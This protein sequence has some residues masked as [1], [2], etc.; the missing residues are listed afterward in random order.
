MRPSSSRYRAADVSVRNGH[1]R[2]NPA[3]M[4]L[5]VPACPLVVILV[6]D[7]LC[8]FEFG[9][10]MEVFALSRPEVGAYWYRCVV[11]GLE[12]GPLRAGPRLSV[13]PDG[14]LSLLDQADTIIVPGW[15]GVDT[16]VPE[17]LVLA[18]QRAHA[19]GVRLVSIS[20]GVFVLA[21]TGLLDGRR[22]TT[23]WHHTEHLAQKYPNIRVLPDVLYTEDE[24]LLTSAGSAAGL[25]LCLYIVRQ[26]FG[27]KIAN[28]VARRLVIPMHRDGG[29]AQFVP[30][31]VAKR[32]GRRLGT[33]FDVV[34]VRL[35]E[36]WPVERMA[37]EAGMS[38]RG[39]HR[40]LRDA[41]GV[42][43]LVWLLN[44]RI[45]LARE[46]LE[47]TRSPISEIARLS[48]FQSEAGFRKQFRR[49][50]GLAASEYRRRFDATV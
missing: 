42:T 39:L 23:H 20:S 13:M 3:R 46:L 24:G 17:E 21:A 32:P 25:D 43:P 44:E 47:T 33:L 27:P 26:D 15:R 6:Y 31:P 28:Q 29:Q 18:L 2:S 40:H 5:P 22:A 9:C 11:A 14:D 19:R 12:E 35:D 10:T 50:S 7:G 49:L 38:A 45:A 34:R 37:L 4:L 16:V 36:D 30:R 8:A 41:T 48:G 1:F